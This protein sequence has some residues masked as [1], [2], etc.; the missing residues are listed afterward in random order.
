MRK[1]Q[2]QFTVRVTSA[3]KILKYEFEEIILNQSRSRVGVEQNI[4]F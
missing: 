3:A 4:V 1:S 2:T